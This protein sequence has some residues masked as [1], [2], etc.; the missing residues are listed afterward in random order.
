MP[1]IRIKAC[2]T[3]RN[4]QQLDITARVWFSTDYYRSQKKSELKMEELKQK[5]EAFAREYF[6]DAYDVEIIWR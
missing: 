2:D 3:G 4:I 5:L 1:H 6:E